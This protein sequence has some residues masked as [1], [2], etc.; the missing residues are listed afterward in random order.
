MPKKDNLMSQLDQ[1]ELIAIKPQLFANWRCLKSIFA[2]KHMFDWR[3]VTFTEPPFT[4]SVSDDQMRD[5]IFNPLTPPAFPCHT[6]AVE[7]GFCFVM[8]AVSSVFG[9]AECNGF[10]CQRIKSWREIGTLDTKAKF[11]PKLEKP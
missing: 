7:T 4:A 8:E 9:T 2:P 6:Q 1:K 3:T 11:F 5:L 10:I